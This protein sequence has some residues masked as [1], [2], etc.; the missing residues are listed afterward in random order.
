MGAVRAAS[1]ERVRA[2]WWTR[3]WRRRRTAAGAAPADEVERRSGRRPRVE[4]DREAHSRSASSYSPAIGAVGD[5]A[6]EVRVQ[7]VAARRTVDRG[8]QVAREP[9]RG[10]HGHRERNCVGPRRE[11]RVPRVDR[12][13][14]HPHVVACR[15]EQRR[16][17]R[18][19]AGLL[20][21]LV[22]RDEQARGSSAQATQRPS[23]SPP[24]P[25]ASVVAVDDSCVRVGARRAPSARTLGL[26][27]VAVS[28]VDWDD[29]DEKRTR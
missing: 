9:G 6:A 20:A 28:R 11:L 29:D 14:E 15:G 24:V 5:V 13:V 4:R 21:E 22:G 3:P 27:V 23:R 18:E 7:A 8:D 26:S 17:S 25:V 16:R 19:V 10:V 12:R 1:V 2:R